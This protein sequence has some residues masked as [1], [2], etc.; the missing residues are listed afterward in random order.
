MHFG[1]GSDL[2]LDAQDEESVD[3]VSVESLGFKKVLIPRLPN[4]DD[5]H[6]VDPMLCRRS[7][8]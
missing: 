7:G 1:Q 6:P 4:A 5:T 8:K 2:Q 3:D